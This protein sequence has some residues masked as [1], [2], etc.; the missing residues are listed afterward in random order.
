MA[1][2]DG[3]KKFNVPTAIVSPP[4]IHGIGK[5]PIKT[6]S[7]QIP[8]LS[9][10]ILK[11]GRGFQVLEGQN[12][13]DGKYICLIGSMA[14]RLP[15]HIATHIDDVAFAF[16]LLVEEALKPKGGKAQWGNSGYY[17]VDGAE[18]VSLDARQYRDPYYDWC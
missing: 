5:G 13:W 17:F 11:R 6:R 15:R 10:A 3:H 9:E 14:E 4:L 16:V 7:I 18:F 1:V 8:Y 2:L 12:I